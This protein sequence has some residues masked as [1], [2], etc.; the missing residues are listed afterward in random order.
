MV[1]KQCIQSL[2]WMRRC[3]LKVFFNRA[4]LCQLTHIS[5]QLWDKPTVTKIIQIKG[6]V[7]MRCTHLLEITDWNIDFSAEMSFTYAALG[8]SFGGKGL[9]ARL[10]HTERLFIDGVFAVFFYLDQTD[11]LW[12]WRWLLWQHSCSQEALW[13]ARVRWISSIR[14]DITV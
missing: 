10:D 4:K 7:S 14:Q 11:G 13:G 6:F 3:R 8:A 1:A 9:S 2:V 5:L 12:L